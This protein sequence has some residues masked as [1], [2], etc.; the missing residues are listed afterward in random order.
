MMLGWDS[1]SVDGTKVEYN[2]SSLVP[3]MLHD[4]DGTKVVF[5]SCVRKPLSYEPSSNAR[6]NKTLGKMRCLDR[7]EETLNGY[8]LAMTKENMSMQNAVMQLALLRR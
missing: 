3:A 7:D 5:A 1:H 6:S 2:H 8:L 4:R